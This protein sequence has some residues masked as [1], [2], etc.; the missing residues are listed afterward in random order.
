MTSAERYKEFPRSYEQ[1]RRI[2]GNSYWKDLTENLIITEGT[3]GIIRLTH[4]GRT[5]V[6]YYPN[7]DMKCSISEN[8][9]QP[10]VTV[11]NTI[12]PNGVTFQFPYLSGT[13]EFAILVQ[14]KTELYSRKYEENTVY[15]EHE[16]HVWLGDKEHRIAW[17][18]DVPSG[19]RWHY[20]ERHGK[21][22]RPVSGYTLQCT[23]KSKDGLTYVE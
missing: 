21:W 3:D 7:G 4:A 10:T 23:P 14:I 22:P 11:I 5:F 17:N 15:L 2:L 9:A 19:V 20:T 16:G 8:R 12:L 1:A 18:L 6:W 13:K